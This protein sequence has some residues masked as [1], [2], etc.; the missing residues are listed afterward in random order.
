MIILKKNE[1]KNT[2]KLTGLGSPDWIYGP[3]AETM[4][5]GGSGPFCAFGIIEGCLYNNTWG[6][7]L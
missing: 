1:K 3:L 4:E 6:T 7:K 2:E 5:N